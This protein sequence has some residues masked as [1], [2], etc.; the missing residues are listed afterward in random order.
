MLFYVA[1]L[2]VTDAQI[3]LVNGQEVINA[4]MLTAPAPSP[5]TIIP[6]PQS[7]WKNKAILWGEPKPRVLNLPDIMTSLSSD[8]N[9]QS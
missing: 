8:Q 2:N 3:T 4:Q 6:M 9:V 1:G 5:S 7:S